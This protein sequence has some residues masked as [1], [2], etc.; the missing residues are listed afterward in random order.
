MIRSI[1]FLAV[2]GALFASNLSAAPAARAEVSDWGSSSCIGEFCCGQQ[3]YD[4]TNGGPYCEFGVNP[5]APEAIACMDKTS[6]TING[7]STN[8]SDARIIVAVRCEVAGW[9]V[10]EWS[11]T[12]VEG[13]REITAVGVCPPEERLVERLC[14]V[15][16][17]D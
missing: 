3:W 10:G 12:Q 8:Q 16:V 5:G 17:P 9:V 7:Q 15:Y 14:A 11:P 4:S 1:S 6:L 13:F 2:T